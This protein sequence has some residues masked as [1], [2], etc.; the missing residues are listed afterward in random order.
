M[1]DNPI[2]S[3][4]KDIPHD[5]AS[6]H[7]AGESLFIDDIAPQRGELFVDY[8]GSP[9]A[10]GRIK[11]IHLDDARKIPGVVAL[12]THKDIPGHNVFGPILKDEH[13][14]ADKIVEFIGDPVV[15]VAAESRAA[16]KAAK[17]AVKIDIDPLPPIFT[18]DEAMEKKSFIANERLVERGDIAAAFAN[19]KHIHEGVLEIGGQEHFYLESQAAV[20]YPGENRTL[21]VHSSTQHPSEVQ[22]V[23][24]EVCGIP[25]NQVISICRR[26]GGGFGGKETQA[27]QPA[28]MAGLVALLTQRPARVVLSKDDDMKFTGKRH[29]FK[30]IYKVA[31]DDQ[32]VIQALDV[33]LYANGGCTCDLSPSV[34]E[35]AMLHTDNCYWIPNIKITGRVCKTN[36]PSNTAFRGFG[37]PQGVIST[38]NILEEIAQKLRLDPIDVRIANLYGIESNNVTPYG[39]IVRNNTLHELFAKARKDSNY[40]WR[41][42]QIATFNAFSRT[43]LRG[44]SLTGV[45][46]GISFTKRTLNQ[47]NALVNI[48]TDGSVMVSH[49][50]TEMGNG[51][52]TRVHQIVADALG[53][54]YS[55][56]T[57][58]VTST[59]KNNNTSPTAASTGTDL[60]GAAALDACVKLRSRLAEFV[61]P[62]LAD[63]SLGLNP[64]PTHV[65]IEN[66]IVFDERMPSRRMCWAELIGRAYF[67]RINLG[68]RGFYATPGVEFNRETGKGSPFLYYTNGVAATEVLIDRF[69]GEMR[70][71]RCDLLVDAGKLINPGI[72]RGQVTGG[73]IQGIGW[74]TSEALRY[75]DK[76][77][78]L[79]YSP[80]TYKIPAISD[81]PEVF[82]VE[83]LDNPNN[84]VSLLRSKALGEPPLLLGTSA[85]TAIKNALSHLT[86]GVV[87]L[88]LPATG[89]EILMVAQQLECGK[90]GK[91]LAAST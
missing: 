62:L 25:F 60:N 27:A 91:S 36:L 78:L 34:L 48:Y 55:L 72:D 76:G 19:A 14:L 56:V 87:T 4:G 30:S 57:V 81:M 8:V 80:T 77:D 26:M 86:E 68:E 51:V 71:L 20:V 79:S 59:E 11:A 42:K 23:V 73:F 75:S 39:Q 31:Y 6:T 18:I 50:G 40:D 90:T 47:A 3:V 21:T 1:S 84:T 22:Q 41:R 66:G 32:G 54:P 24:A 53:I 7:V 9:V 28:A 83:F 17:K 82:N 5:S 49:G 45:K 65:K 64:S 15:L 69:T 58:G 29:P 38:E 85:W 63:A 10:H 37:G 46:F 44:L 16:L 2:A 33:Q 12:F 52:H 70:L 35:R 89:E 13:L 74:C 67:D 88:A 43:H 61:A